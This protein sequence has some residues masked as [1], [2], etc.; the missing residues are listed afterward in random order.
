MVEASGND[1]DVLMM[2]RWKRYAQK[3]GVDERK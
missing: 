2:K 3:R 1:S